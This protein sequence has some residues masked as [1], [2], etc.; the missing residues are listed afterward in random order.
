MQ[1]FKKILGIIYLHDVFSESLILSSDKIEY[2]IDN[3]SVIVYIIVFV[4]F[5]F[6]I[7]C[8]FISSSKKNKIHKDNIFKIK[9][10]NEQLKQEIQAFN[11]NN[12]KIKTE[13]EQ[14]K[15]EI[16]LLNTN[17]LNIKAENE[18]LKQEIKTL[19]IN[20]IYPSHEQTN[21]N[22]TT[23][24]TPDKPQ[25]IQYVETDN[26][27]Y[28]TDGK[29]ITDEE[30]PY[31]IQIGYEKAL[32][33]E[34]ESS[35]PKFHRTEEEEELCMQFIMNYG[36][37]IHKHTISFEDAYRQAYSEKDLDK[38]I[39]LLQ[40]VIDLFEKEKK[41][42]YKTKGG[43]IYFQDFYEH[44]H[45]SRDADFSYIDSVRDYLEYNIHKQ[46]CIIPEIT[47]LIASMGGIMQKDIYSHFPDE[48]KSDIQ[49]IIRE[50]GNNN[51]ILRTKKGN[52]Y[53]LTLNHSQ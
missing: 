21:E 10:E 8:I 31:L 35:N 25:D 4:C 3:V 51:I 19:N 39:L 45:N 33:K 37:D 13:N 27:I 46:D 12:S 16:Q 22:K 48:P 53:F 52:S 24:F 26:V 28:R 2:P 20:T 18:Q 32:N 41:W 50:L 38:K 17:T 47:H 43:T 23:I 5:L 44:M 15:Q 34:K 42:F 1:I 9:A 40:N 36:N 7:F 29:S 30:I 6:Y 14:L 49:K 11:I